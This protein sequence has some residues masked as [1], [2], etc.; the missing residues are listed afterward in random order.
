M[1]PETVDCSAVNTSKLAKLTDED[2]KTLRRIGGCFSC[3]KAENL[4]EYCLLLAIK[5]RKS[6]SNRNNMQN[7]ILEKT[8]ATK[9]NL[10]ENQ[11]EIPT[12]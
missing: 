8:K 10:L 9:V 7:R 6:I 3:R 12:Y 2:R 11:R 5:S 4:L 1:K